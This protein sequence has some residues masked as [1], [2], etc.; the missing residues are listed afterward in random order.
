M[1]QNFPFQPAATA[2]NTSNIVVT[3]SNQTF[4]LSPTVGSDGGTV[5][6]TNIGTQTVFVALGTVTASLTT[7]MPVL[8][9]SIETFSLPGGVNTLSVIAASTGS[10][11]YATVGQG[12]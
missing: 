6:M 10:T 4:T 1:Q 7:S 5:R 11:L 12:T 3:G 9:N 8:A 2:A